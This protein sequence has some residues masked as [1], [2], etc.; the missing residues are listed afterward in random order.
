MIRRV[1]TNVRRLQRFLL[2][3]N[4]LSSLAFEKDGAGVVAASGPVRLVRLS[5]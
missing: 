2:A 5:E 3:Q 4:S 1:N